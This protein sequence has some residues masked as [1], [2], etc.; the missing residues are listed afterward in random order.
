MCMCEYVSAYVCMAYMSA[1]CTSLLVSRPHPLH[2]HEEGS[3]ED[4][5][6]L[7]WNA[8]RTNRITGAKISRV[9]YQ[10]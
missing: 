7:Y 8:N 3:G 1:C 2:A 6:G 10:L 5:L 9:M 4:V